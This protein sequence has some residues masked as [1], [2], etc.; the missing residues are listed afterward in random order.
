[1]LEFVTWYLTSL[2]VDADMRVKTFRLVVTCSVD[3]VFS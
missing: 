2:S 3:V 1:M